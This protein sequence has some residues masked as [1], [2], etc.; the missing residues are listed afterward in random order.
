MQ[1]TPGGKIVQGGWYSTVPY[2]TVPR[3]K[4]SRSILRDVGVVSPT[5]VADL[6]V[7]F[8]FSPMQPISRYG[9]TTEYLL[10]KSRLKRRG[11]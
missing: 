5:K 2:C 3:R 11:N 8:W 7:V 4:Q 10:K 6:A 1:K 9:T